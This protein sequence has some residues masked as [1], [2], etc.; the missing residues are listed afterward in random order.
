ML[1]KDPA[2]YAETAVDDEIVIM[3]LHSGDFFSLTGTA[4]AV[5]RLLDGSHDREALLTALSKE[6][7]VDRSDIVG[8][9]D[10]FLT[11]IASAGLLQQAP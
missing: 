9:V 1:T 10:S 7:G 5:W 2:R 6:Y 3:A 8:E 4:A 11:E